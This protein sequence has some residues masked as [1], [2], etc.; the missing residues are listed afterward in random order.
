MLQRM[1]GIIPVL[2]MKE[3]YGINTK[4]KKIAK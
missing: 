1:H 2:H 4:K 3:V